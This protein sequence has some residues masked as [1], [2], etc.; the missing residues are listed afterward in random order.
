LFWQ[1]EKDTK[2]GEESSPVIPYTVEELFVPSRHLAGLI[3]EGLTQ[4]YCFWHSVEDPSIIRGYVLPTSV[5]ECVIGCVSYPCQHVQM[6]HKVSDCAYKVKTLVST[7]CLNEDEQQRTVPCSYFNK[8]ACQ[9]SLLTYVFVFT[10]RYKLHSTTKSWIP[11]ESTEHAIT[12]KLERIDQVA[13]T[14]QPGVC[15]RVIRHITGKA[16]GKVDESSQSASDSEEDFSSNNHDM[17]S[18]CTNQV[19]LNT[20]HS[21]SESS[22]MS[23][24]RTLCR[25]EHA[26]HL[27]VWA[28][29]VGVSSEK[30]SQ[31][32][33]KST[34]GKDKDNTRTAVRLV[35]VQM[36]RLA[37]KFVVKT[38]IEGPRQDR[39]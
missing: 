17:S 13:C 35:S 37:A 24:T 8:A 12:M 36:T 21:R 18:T 27:L 28:E 33:S 1:A 31:D 15:A 39:S 23:I 30:T 2:A 22:V 34:D 29:P 10:C 16:Q 9:T 26:S 20:L 3:P 19:L 38:Y 4:E 7:H 25:A 6:V 32:E 5:F 11:A 14:Q